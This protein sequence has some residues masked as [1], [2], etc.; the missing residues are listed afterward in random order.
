MRFLLTTDP[1]LEDVAAA[2]ARERGF[3]ASERPFGYAGLVLAEGEDEGELFS[4]RSVHHV[5]RHLG[6]FRLPLPTL[7]GA[8]AA[9][10]GIE[11]PELA[12]GKSFAV[13]VNRRGEHGF[14]SPELERAL[15]E[16]LVRRYRAPVR[17]EDPDVLLRVDLFD[18]EALVGVQLTK[19]ALSL[20]YPKVYAPMAA[21]KTTV[22][23]GM[24]RL[25]GAEEGA[26]LDA[27]TGSGTIAIEAAQAF[28]GLSPVVGVDISTKAVAG[29]EE[30]A[31][32][33][34]VLDRVE[35]RR[36]DSR[37]LDRYFSPESF[38]FLLANPPYGKRLGKREDLF[39]LYLKFMHSARRVLR[40]GGRLGLLVLKRGWVDRLL[41]IVGCFKV[42][43]RRVIEV[44][45]LYPGFFVLERDVCS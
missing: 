23:Y 33:A 44:G 3:E 27:F 40:P 32:S 15:G 2:E 30:N 21:L 36:A 6:A 19:K 28:P 37:F 17:L 14:K 41:K 12:E 38:D 18:Q 22:A 35:F 7:E 25:V 31:K 29:A 34:G 26:L 4:L 5:V 9:L 8:I 43:H 45:G 42:R 39:G 1:G 11:L 20:R 16:V 10:G 13:R 24:L